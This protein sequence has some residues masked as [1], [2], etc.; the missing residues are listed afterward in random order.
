MGATELIGYVGKNCVRK[1]FGSMGFRDFNALN[2]A[3]LENQGWKFISDTNILSSRIFK[4]KYFLKRNF[5]SVQLEHNPSFIWKNIW[6]SQILL[7]KRCRWRIEDDTNIN[8][9]TNPRLRDELNFYVTTPR[10]QNLFDFKIND[11]LVEGQKA[12]DIDF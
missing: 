2:V 7:Q 4:T 1:E 6:C 9:W 3:M 10:D 8:V 5:L 11:F 12:W